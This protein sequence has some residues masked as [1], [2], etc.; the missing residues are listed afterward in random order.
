MGRAV[1]PTTHRPYGQSCQ[2]N[3][4]Q[5]IWAELSD[6]R[7]TG[8]MGRAVRPRRHKG[9]ADRTAIRNKTFCPRERESD[10]D[11]DRDRQRE[12]GR[13]RGEGVAEEEVCMCVCVCVWGGGGVTNWL[14]RDNPSD[15]FSRHL[16]SLASSA[17]LQGET[18]HAV[19]IE[20]RVLM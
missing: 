2:T 14:R 4:T 12:R 19:S 17:E 11:R 7:H 9:H 15:V 13:G 20:R 8:H 3:D 5:A 10:R 1:R 18:I 6:Q 16:D